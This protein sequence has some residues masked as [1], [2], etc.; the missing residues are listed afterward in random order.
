LKI[1]NNRDVLAFLAEIDLV[2]GKIADVL[3]VKG[4][5]PF[6]KPEKNLNLSGGVGS[7]EHI[8]VVPRHPSVGF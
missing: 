8:L 7:L 2:N 3:K 1:K 5:C 4:S 6:G